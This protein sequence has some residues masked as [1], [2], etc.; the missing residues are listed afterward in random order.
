MAQ[1]LCPPLLTHLT[2]ALSVFPDCFLSSYPSLPAFQ[3]SP[4][5][6]RMAE[7]PPFLLSV[8][9]QSQE[10]TSTETLVSTHHSL[11]SAEQSQG[12][13]IPPAYC[14]RVLG[15]ISIQRTS[16][17]FRPHP[18]PRVEWGGAEMLYTCCS[19]GCHC[20]LLAGTWRECSWRVS[21][22]GVGVTPDCLLCGKCWGWRSPIGSFEA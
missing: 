9:S 2:S 20:Y 6:P 14:H 18:M 5:S 1:S 21:W 11:L 16:A 12:R 15:I 19:G 4:N 3:C 13:G 17:R 10:R 8:S 22:V 7:M